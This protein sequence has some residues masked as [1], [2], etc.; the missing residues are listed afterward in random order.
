M[1]SSTAGH[2]ACIGMAAVT[3]HIRISDGHIVVL[4]LI[5]LARRVAV[6][7][8]RNR[9]FDVH[10]NR[11]MTIGAG[12]R[13]TKQCMMALSGFT[14]VTIVAVK[15]TRCISVAGSAIG[16]GRSGCVMNFLGSLA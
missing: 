7:A 10:L 4:L 16:L 13:S 1:A 11:I 3:G 14:G 15:W 6:L 12:Q 8:V 2:F 9:R 5:R